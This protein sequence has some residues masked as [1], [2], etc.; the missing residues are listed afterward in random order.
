MTF[1]RGEILCD[2]LTHDRGRLLV[3]DC[4]RIVGKV[5]ASG[6]SKIILENT[7]VDGRLRELDGGEITVDTIR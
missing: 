1:T 6:M 7:P 3:E 4:K 5:E 2:V